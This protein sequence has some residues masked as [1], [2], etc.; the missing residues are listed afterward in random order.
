MSVGEALNTDT[1]EDDVTNLTEAHVM[2]CALKA[3][4]L[5]EK[6]T[7]RVKKKS[8]HGKKKYF[9]SNNKHKMKKQSRAHNKSPRHKAESCRRTRTMKPRTDPRTNRPP[10]VV[11]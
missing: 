4:T 9:S 7:P 1:H 10:P 8:K 2:N 11:Y 3:T 6:Q 5:R